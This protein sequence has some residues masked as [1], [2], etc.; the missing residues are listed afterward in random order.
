MGLEQH[1][2]AWIY[3]YVEILLFLYDVYVICFIT[4]F[5]SGFL[6]CLI[7][8]SDVWTFWQC[9]ISRNWSFIRWIPRM[10]F[11][12]TG[13]RRFEALAFVIFSNRFNDERRCDVNVVFSVSCTN[14]NEYAQW[15]AQSRSMSLYRY[16]STLVC[17]DCIEI[18]QYN[19][20]FW[21]SY[22]NRIF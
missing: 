1:C 11:C 6:W 16:N 15:E 3:L 4:E 12:D 13:R 22:K 18:W 14:W 19:E 17:H 20:L 21:N 7:V 10:W 8:L 9:R 2:I 5:V